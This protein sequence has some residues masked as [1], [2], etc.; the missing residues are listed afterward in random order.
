MQPGLDLPL[1]GTVADVRDKLEAQAAAAPGFV[2]ARVFTCFCC[3][4]KYRRGEWRCCAPIGGMNPQAW[5]AKAHRACPT[6]LVQGPGD[7]RCAKHCRCPRTAENNL[8]PPQVVPGQA[9][10][11]PVTKAIVEE[12]RVEAASG[13]RSTPPMAADDPF[14][15]SEL[16]PP[17]EGA[18]KLWPG[19]K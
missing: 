7:T 19:A 17:R 1:A 5:M 9:P 3:G 18:K 11:I 16:P 4:E 15:V 10:S 14:M 2:A 13:R 6:S 12:I 8:L